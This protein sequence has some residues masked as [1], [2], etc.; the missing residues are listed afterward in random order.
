MGFFK[1]RLWWDFQTVPVN[2]EPDCSSTVFY[3]KSQLWISRMRYLMQSEITLMLF[4]CPRHLSWLRASCCRKQLKDKTYLW[5]LVFGFHSHDSE[6][7]HFISK[8]LKYLIFPFFFFSPP[9]NCSTFLLQVSKEIFP[10]ERSLIIN[11]SII[12]LMLNIGNH[13][14]NL[15]IPWK[16]Y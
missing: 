5:I 8:L 12:C 15:P 13:P 7:P 4:L 9:Q 10:E 2:I 6:S 11:L 16:L 3:T 1:Q 14:C